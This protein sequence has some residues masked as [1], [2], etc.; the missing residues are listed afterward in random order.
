MHTYVRTSWSS[1]V[2]G[3]VDEILALSSPAVLAQV[4]SLVFPPNQSN[5]RNSSRAVESTQT[6]KPVH[7]KTT[8]TSIN[9][10]PL[11]YLGIPLANHQA[12]HA[13]TQS[14][15]SLYT[16]NDSKKQPTTLPVRI[17]PTR[18]AVDGYSTRLKRRRRHRGD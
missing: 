6:R 15:I 5:A 1:T 3:I 9:L 12:S 7:W 4:L 18:K 16:C 10:Q 2:D 13:R 11:L 14:S 8:I 17:V